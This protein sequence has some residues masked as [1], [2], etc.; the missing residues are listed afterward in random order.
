MEY[1]RKGEFLADH[2]GSMLIIPRFEVKTPE[3]KIRSIL[4]FKLIFDF[5]YWETP[6]FLDH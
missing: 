6:G 4:L 1:P 3:E 2:Q 5:K